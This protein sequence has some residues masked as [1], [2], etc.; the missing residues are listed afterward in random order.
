MRRKIII[1]I[2]VVCFI[3]FA[4]SCQLLDPDKP[5]NLVPRTVDE[6]SSLPSLEINGTNV[7]LETFG[8]PNDPCI[9]FLHGGPGIDYRGFTRLTTLSDTYFLIMFDQRGTGLSRRHD[10]DEISTDIYIADL[11][12]II[13][14]YDPLNAVA[15]DIILLGHSWGCQ[16]A[17]MYTSRYPGKV[18]RLILIEPGPL[19]DE[20]YDTY[21][22]DLYS[23]PLS[24]EWI[25]DWVWSED[26]ISPDTHARLDYREIQGAYNFGPE[27]NL[28]TTD[29]MPYWRLG[30]V[31]KAT[32]KSEGISGSETDWDFTDGIEIFAGP[33][34]FIRGSLNQ[35]MTD[36]YM[37]HVM[38]SYFSHTINKPY[39]TI[40]DTGH[41][42]VWVASN[43]IMTEIRN[44]L[45]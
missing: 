26:F 3:I 40:A 5:G 4:G 33:V 16:Y 20:D 11:N 41:D 44:F 37:Q 42:L 28:S 21:F 30:K 1:T 43:E 31:A 15:N 35:V 25:N 7:H 12:A 27:Y 6:D 19:T 39:V 13:D 8:D 24:E 36:E 29:R 14:F 17:A 32:L 10:P 34:L 9:I 18:G 23:P 45:P 38:A 22:A 2:I